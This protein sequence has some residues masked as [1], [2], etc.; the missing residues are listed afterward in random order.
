MRS[1]ILLSGG[2]DSTTLGHYIKKK[3]KREIYLIS[4]FYGQRHSKEIEYAIYQARL[5][6]PIEHKIVDI[7]FF[8]SLIKNSALI[9]REINIPTWQDAQK[10]MPTSYVPFRN[11]VFLSISLSYAESNDIDEIYYAAQRQDYIGY[12]D[13]REEFVEKLNEL[14]SLNPKKKIKI[15]A[16]FVNMRK[17][18]IVKLGIELNVD[19]S[20]TWSCYKGE[21]EP[22]KVCPSCVDRK[23]AFM[24]A[25]IYD[26]E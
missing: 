11:L 18:E 22:C 3:L 25:G 6:E 1:L 20:K 7:S 9:N 16:P 14:A 23:K 13:C 15:I 2:I 12:W 8:S 24:E 4:F 19:Y 10:E 21:N 17:S 5:L 26:I